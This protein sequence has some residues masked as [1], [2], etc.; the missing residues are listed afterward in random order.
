MEIVDEWEE[1]GMRK[2]LVRVLRRHFGEFQPDL[3]QRIQQLSPE[4]IEQLIG[5]Y[6]DMNGVTELA[7]WIEQRS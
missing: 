7:A 5:A 2:M 4:Q 3:L 1:A 6:Q